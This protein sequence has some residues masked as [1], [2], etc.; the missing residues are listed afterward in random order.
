MSEEEAYKAMR[1][2]AMGRNKRLVDVAD[3]IVSAASLLI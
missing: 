2:L 1:S 3:S